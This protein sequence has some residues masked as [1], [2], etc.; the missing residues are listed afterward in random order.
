[1]KPFKCNICNYETAYKSELKKH[2][3]QSNHGG[4]KPVKCAICDGT[5]EEKMKLQKHLNV[6]HGKKVPLDSL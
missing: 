1:M 2:I 3:E 6:A 5:F 4:Q